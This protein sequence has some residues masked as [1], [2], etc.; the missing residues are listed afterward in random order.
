MKVAFE[1][2]SVVLRQRVFH[3]HGAGEEEEAV[4][5]EDVMVQV[6][7]QLFERTVERAVAFAGVGRR[8]VVRRLSRPAGAEFDRV[9]CGHFPGR[10]PPGSSPARSRT[11]GARGEG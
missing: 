5:D 8:R 10:P 11:A 9:D 2:A 3:L 7:L 6:G 1:V 4:L